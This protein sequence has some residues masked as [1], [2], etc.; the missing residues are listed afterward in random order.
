M[1]V[2]EI[3]TF[4]EGAFYEK[5]I[6]GSPMDFCIK[7]SHIF[8]FHFH[9]SKTI[10]YSHLYVNLEFKLRWAINLENIDIKISF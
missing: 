7:N 9:F 8:E 2:E 4:M 5:I 1:S 10:K 6:H 3:F